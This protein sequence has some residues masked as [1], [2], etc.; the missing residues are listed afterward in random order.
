M[1]R[2]KFTINARLKILT[3][4]MLNRVSRRVNVINPAALLFIRRQTTCKSE[5]LAMH[6]CCALSLCALTYVHGD[7]TV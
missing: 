4:L 6:V 7:F 2:E 3:R 5:N 1:G